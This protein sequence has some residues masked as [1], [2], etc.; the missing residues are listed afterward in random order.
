M[1]HIASFSG[2]KDSTALILH[3]QEVG[4][5][6]RTVFCDTGWEHPIAMEYVD[7]IDRELLGGKLIRLKSEKYDGFHDLAVKRKMVPGLRSRFCTQ[8]LKIFPLH[9][10]LDTLEDGDITVYQGIR[11]EESPARAAMDKKT[12]EKDAGGFWID[13][14]LKDWTAEQVFEIHKRY[15][16][17]P[18]PLYTMGMGRVG[19]WPCI[20]V[21][22]RELKHWFRQFPDTVEKLEAL[23]ADLN[24]NLEDPN[25][26][27]S[28][29]RGDY[30]PERFKHDRMCI[31][32]DGRK[33][34]IPTVQEVY[35]YLMETD[36]KQL[37]LWESPKCMSIYNLCE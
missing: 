25:S 7:K 17:T 8:E 32:K 36:D 9:A 26:P 19:C 34:M 4:I 2:G 3:M 21:S 10:Y 31:T 28:F 22:K 11:S 37:G 15:G 27:R 33:E 20:M 6:F 14:P 29:F 35:K 13:R 18:N 23:E 24:A 1:I 12:W 5:E 16:V 30:I